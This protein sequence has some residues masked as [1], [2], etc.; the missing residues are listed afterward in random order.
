MEACLDHNMVG[1]IDIW[2][3]ILQSLHKNWDFFAERKKAG[4]R[5]WFYTCL[6]PDGEYA[7]RFV[8]LPL[9]K[10]RLLHWINFRYGIEGYLHWGFNFWRPYPWENAGSRD[11]PGG[12]THIVYPSKA[13][14]G[15]IE[16]IRW[17]AMRDGIE[18]HELLSQLAEKDPDAAMRLAVR[19]IID[20]DKYDTDLKTFRATRRELLEALSR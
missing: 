9:I 6:H 15:I 5:V 18:D 3:P 2:V 20:W 4:D 13:G 16:S 8:E 17:E 10:T 1:A 7:N 14:P 11:L 12:D 19:H